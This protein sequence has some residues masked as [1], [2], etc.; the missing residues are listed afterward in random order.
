MKKPTKKLRIKSTSSVQEPIRA[1]K[2]F[3]LKNNY[4][5]GAVI[6]RVTPDIKAKGNTEHIV[7]VNLTKKAVQKRMSLVVSKKNIA[8]LW[9]STENTAKG[10]GVTHV[11][12]NF[13]TQESLKLTIEYQASCSQG[14]QEQA[15]VGLCGQ[16]AP[17]K[18]LYKCIDRVIQAFVQT[19]KEAGI[20]IIRNFFEFQ[21][22]LK[23]DIQRKVEAKTGLTFDLLLDIYKADEIDQIDLKSGIFTTKVKDY[24]ED[25]PL[26]F[27]IGLE[28]DEHNKIQAYTHQAPHLEAMIKKEIKN[29]LLKEVS[30]NEL[31]REL[32]GRVM[33]ALKRLL[34]IRLTQ[35]GR[36]ITYFNLT[37]TP[38]VEIPRNE[39]VMTHTVKCD[40]QRYPNPVEIE[41]RVILTLNDISKYNKAK[42][43]NL[44]RWVKQCLENAIE[45]V[46]AKRTY[47]NILLDLEEDEAKVKQRIQQQA[48]AIGFKVEHI[49]VKP[50]L[51]ELELIEGF[52]VKFDAHYHT[53]NHQVAIRLQAIL[54]GNIENLRKI[55]KY[56]NPS[57]DFKEKLQK[58]VRSEIEH[59]IHTIDPERAYM[60]FYQGA[61]GEK[62]V[63]EEIQHKVIHS[64]DPYHISNITFTLKP[65]ETEITERFTALREGYHSF[66]LGLMPLRDEGEGEKVFYKVLFK[67]QR[68]DENGWYT[69]QANNYT[70]KDEVSALTDFL[71]DDLRSRL[72]TV[73]NV[74]LRYNEYQDLDEIKK[75]ADMSL[76]AIVQTFGLV[77]ELIGFR[78]Q[79][80]TS[81]QQMVKT[82]EH[83]NETKGRIDRIK[84]RKEMTTLSKHEVKAYQSLLEEKDR[85]IEQGYGE[86]EEDLKVVLKRIKEIEEQSSGNIIEQR[87]I[88]SKKKKAAT[89]KKINIRNEFNILPPTDNQEQGETD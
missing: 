38:N 70:Q 58:A 77:I 79:A 36:K 18:A 52:E 48:E 60:R 44:E 59:F 35:Y 25:V 6:R 82:T 75:V 73:P 81:E 88:Q 41:N 50:N 86:D 45:V 30:L 28:I 43:P 51:K 15:A 33:P 67:V 9:V 22:E 5:L 11:I 27:K 55:E 72:E 76:K 32:Q 40:L 1:Q 14:N 78:R 34:N 80:T 63:E 89:R 8:Y 2:P 57:I 62:S 74:L 54:T 24:Q 64:L 12:E 16:N 4:D 85:L 17:G 20:N 84:I 87:R 21:G 46:F 56:L 71:K 7:K 39:Q 69:F 61:T 13:E 10:S 26:S 49:F 3:Q 53:K 83:Y 29:Y 66:M 31:Y 42:V 19:K 47:V 37:A 65:L 23:S 68:I